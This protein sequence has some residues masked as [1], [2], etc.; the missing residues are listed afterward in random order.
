MTS[1]I[2]FRLSILCK[3]HLIQPDFYN[4]DLERFTPHWKCP[5]LNFLTQWQWV[6]HLPAMAPIEP[7]GLL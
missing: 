4:F 6:L 1:I 7:G 2:N 5:R 3:S